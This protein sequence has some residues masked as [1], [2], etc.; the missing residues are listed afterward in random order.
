MD[1]EKVER[2][3]VNFHRSGVCSM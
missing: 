3:V 1:E 2:M